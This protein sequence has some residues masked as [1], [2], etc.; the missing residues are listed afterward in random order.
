MKSTFLLYNIIGS[1]VPAVSSQ[2][3]KISTG[4]SEKLFFV[5][6]HILAYKT[7]GR[8]LQNRGNDKKWENL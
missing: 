7:G 3:V 2:Y 6:E 5:Y 4:Y 1:E 8:Y